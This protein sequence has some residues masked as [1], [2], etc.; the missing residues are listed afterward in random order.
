MESP[1]TA[2]CAASGQEIPHSRLSIGSAEE[3]ALQEVVRSG[4]LAQGP[5]VAELESAMAATVGTAPPGSLG[6]VAVS[7]ATAALYLALRA[8]GVGPGDEVLLPGYVCAAVLQAVRHAGATPC[9]VDCDTQTWNM[10]PADAG[11][12]LTSRC[13]AIIVPH[14]FGLPADLEPLLALGPPVIEDCAQTLAAEYRGRPVGAFGQASV[15]SFY[16]TK[17]LGAGEG[18]MV[19]S[20]ARELLARVA[21]DRNYEPDA[22]GARDCD[23]QAVEPTASAPDP[24][25]HGASSIGGFNF[26]M[27]DLQAAVALAQ[28]RRLPE[29]LQR[30]QALA[31][32]FREDLADL[33]ITLPAQPADRTHQY[34]RFVVTID[35]DLTGVL[36]RTEAL[37]L[38]CR[39][40]VGWLPEAVRERLES[41]PGCRWAWEHAC[42]IPLFPALTDE[43]AGMVVDRFRRA[44]RGNRISAS[45]GAEDS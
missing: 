10:D 18:G 15:C 37:G 16:A 1:S 14:L 44:V 8:L 42:S 27:T 17:L 45:H 26:K 5:R 4:W 13:G 12:R 3:T 36:Q 38:A 32:R 7:S 6:A 28:L 2:P 24:S 22:A 35:T 34:Y 20:S 29:L 39:R 11:R 33:P 21:G 19:L 43:E 25:S 9:F 41:L 23:S 30:R 31:A 40:P